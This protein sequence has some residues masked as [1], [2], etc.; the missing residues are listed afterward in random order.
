[1][2]G[3]SSGMVH[4][5]ISIANDEFDYNTDTVVGAKGIKKR[6][7]SRYTKKRAKFWVEKACRKRNK[8][9]HSQKRENRWKRCSAIVIGNCFSLFS[10]KCFKFCLTI[11]FISHFLYYAGTT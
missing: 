10:Y 1:M 11:S 2:D 3:E 6:D 9:L 7:C 5:T 8:N 4:V